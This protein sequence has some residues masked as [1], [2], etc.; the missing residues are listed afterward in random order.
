MDFTFD[1]QQMAIAEAAQGIFEGL[2][3]PD[4]VAQ[5]EA[6]EERVDRELWA[7]LA[8]ADL[9]GLGTPEAH[10]GIDGGMVEIGQVLVTQGRVVAPVPIHATLVEGV[11]PIAR[12]GTESLKSRILPE[13]VA[14]QLM[15]SGALADAA[16]SPTLTPRVTAHEVDGAWTLTGTASAVPFAHVAGAIV[17]PAVTSAGEII[18]SVVSTDDSSVSM[19]RTET[20][21]RAVHPHVNFSGTT[22]SSDALLGGPSEGRAVLAQMLAWAQTGLALIQVGV[23]EA[24]IRQTA[25]H[26][27]ERT[28]FGRTLSSFQGTM[29][30]AADAGID[31]EVV[32]VTAWQAAWRL[33]QGMSADEAVLVAKWQAAER[34]Q[35]V[36]HA[37]QHLHG[38]TGAD[39]GY[40]IHRYFLWGKQIEL[41]L[42]SP[43]LQLARLGAL[44]ADEPEKVIAR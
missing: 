27:N 9:L 25:D 17:V 24:A 43:S 37:T 19:E 31:T 21:N 7:A 35:R 32:R 36:V 41:E 4:R 22:V 28:Q 44:I 39:I 23:C 3:D 14:G 1:E 15:L 33:D 18:V 12:W 34:G 10:G 13:V 8:S 38:G 42:G 20:T 40:P 30:R 2:V 26:L 5:V 6:S 16:A 29:L 11:L